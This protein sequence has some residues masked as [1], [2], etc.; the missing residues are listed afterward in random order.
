MKKTIFLFFTMLIAGMVQA[1]QNTGFRQG[2]IISP[3]V[4]GKTVTFKLY[5]PHAQKVS[6][7]GDWEAGGGKANMLK[8]TSGTWA[9]TVN[10]LP[11][12]IYFYR[13]IVDDLTIVDPANVFQRRDVGTL[14]SVFIIGDGKGDYY[15][16]G[17]VPHGNVIRSWYHSNVFKTDRRLTIYTPPGYGAGKYPVLYLLHGSGGD[18]ES[19]L[20]TGSMERIMDNLIAQG[21][22]VPMI[23]VMPNGNP[24]KQAAPG[25]TKDNFGYRPA[26]SNNFPGYKDGTYESAFNEIVAFTDA[27]YATRAEKSQR[28]IAGLSMGGFHSLFISAN[29]PYTFDYVGLFSP[30]INF[31][32]LNMNYAPYAHIDDKLV[33]LKKKG[34][35]LY[36]IGIG[37]ADGLMPYVKSYRAKLDSLAFPYT[38]VESSRGHLWTNWRSYLLQFAPQ[39][40]RK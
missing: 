33:Q 16:V 21:K 17:D 29:Y 6:V 22:A 7:T 12:D 25:E 3:I 40:F 11:S 20:T 27:H 10:N 5:A 30:G 32:T 37:S 9:C 35:K 24:S 4:S 23:V 34:V 8:D 14:F 36:W 31:S 18:E 1:Q 13:F 39:L 38:Y 15:S 19:W 2:A 26:M 28:A